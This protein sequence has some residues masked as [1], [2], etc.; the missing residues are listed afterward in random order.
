MEEPKMFSD[1][2]EQF[3]YTELNVRVNRERTKE[4]AELEIANYVEKAKEIADS[5]PDESLPM[6]IRY[7]GAEAIRAYKERKASEIVAGL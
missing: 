4:F 7:R 5:I 1:E 2:I 3:N 6:D